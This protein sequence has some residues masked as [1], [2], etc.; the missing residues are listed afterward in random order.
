MYLSSIDLFGFKSFAQKTHISFS[1]GVTAI[2]GPN[3]CGKS[4]LVDA[5]RWV[6]GEQRE[7]ALR[8]ER[9]ENVIFGGTAKRRPLGMAE[10]SLTLH[11]SD[12][13]LPLE[14]HEVTVTRRLFRSG[15]SEYL[16]NKTLCRLK[17][18]VD[19]FMDTGVSPE[20]YS[21]IELKMV[22][23]IVTEDPSEMR[24]L[25]DEATGVT[26][27]KYR[28]R[29]ALRRLDEAKQDH[30]RALDILSEVDK[31]AAN[32]KKQV[33]KLRAYKRL[34]DKARQM[35]LVL[36]LNRIRQ[37]QS[38][39]EP[40]DDAL[41]N[42]RSEMEL[43]T[44]HLQTAEAEVLRIEGEIAELES[45]RQKSILDFQQVEAEFNTRSK[46][47]TRLEE[48]IRLNQWKS[49]RNQDERDANG[50]EQDRIKELI[51][52]AD[53]ALKE[54][55][56]KLPNLQ[57]TLSDQEAFFQQADLK[58][59]EARSNSAQVRENLNQVRGKESDA[60]RMAEQ[61]KASISSLIGR[62]AELNFRR[63]EMERNLNSKN[64]ELTAAEQ[65][66][67]EQNRELVQIRGQFAENKERFEA[68]RERLHEA[69]R[70][71]ADAE[72]LKSQINLQIQHYGELHRRSSPL[73]AAGG[74]I[75]HKFP[76]SVSAAL[77]DELQTETAYIQAVETALQGMA[78]A[79]V[80]NERSDFDP[81][82]NFLRTDKKGRAA[83]LL[84]PPPDLVSSRVQ[85][86]IDKAAGNPLRDIVEGSSDAA[87]WIRYFLAD[88]VLVSSREELV[89]F[90]PL[91]AELMVC[92]VTQDGEFFDDRGIWILGSPD[93]AP[94]APAGVSAQLG[95]LSPQLLVTE[96]QIKALADKTGKLRKELSIIEHTLR[97]TEE[98]LHH[99][100]RSFETANS[101]RLNLEAQVISSR[102]LLE[103]V[104]SE[105][106]DVPGRIEELSSK[107]QTET[108]AISGVI[109]NVREL[110][111]ALDQAIAAEASAMEQREIQ[112]QA[113]A[114]EQIRTERIRLEVSRAQDRVSELQNRYDRNA[115]RL[116]V[117][118]QEL[119]Q[120]SVDRA[121]L[122]HD[123][124]E[125]EHQVVEV[126]ALLQES[127]EKLGNIDFKRR[128]LL[129]AQ[130]NG[131]AQLRLLR[132]KLEEITNAIHKVQL[133]RV[134]IE[135]AL[136]EEQRK[137]P[138]GIDVEKIEELEADA[139][140]LTDLERRILGM[141]PL[142]MAAEEEFQ[143]LQQRLDFLNNQ[144]KD[145]EDAQNSLQQ[146]IT[147]LNKEA[148]ERFSTGFE[149]IRTNFQGIFTE[150]FEG[151]QADMKLVDDDPLESSVEILA[152]PGGKKIGSL[153]LLS[154]G[155]KALTAISLLF[156]IYME[157]PSPF[158]VLD[159]VDA[160]LDDLNTRR[161]CH[162]LEKFTPR[163]QFLV[164]THNKRTMEIAKNLLGITMED[165]GISRVV[166]VQIDL[167]S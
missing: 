15:K 152:N 76:K 55:T 17:D 73:Y 7:A 100:E 6:L 3:G 82:I 130:R 70:E 85:A 147:T 167:T 148:R 109:T 11:D 129:E 42:F 101:Q 135:A 58:F 37:L 2:V 90:A 59:R 96:A 31:Q 99:A 95:K 9:M 105:I 156:A 163:T 41:N 154:G 158:C 98:Q 125:L 5:I 40:L 14:Y 111:T 161:F 67:K 136:Q 127:R 10:I 117:L 131:S 155:E 35:R 120:L 13:I 39:L 78:Y 157:K 33:A 63:E 164:V 160:P 115:D 28:R 144:L 86:F 80:V 45:E 149:R 114:E 18:V 66:Q 79:R 89:K 75:A 92:L 97:T 153:A 104:R 12:G 126:T 132:F 138:Q 140:L 84:G 51:S 159:E 91:A 1:P 93:A 102:L 133:D 134:E 81:I 88:V 165:E 21:I 44:G 46:E 139:E 49:N 145:L 24:Y 64:A 4:N 119:A 150:V 107:E 26:R 128:D 32:L 122:Q 19:L 25:L 23:G 106:S 77:A 43:S 124:E 47:K 48:A 142:N 113:L 110:E 8:S 29:E 62:L 57:K 103:Q 20:S 61:C 118:D 69:E 137:L 72:A 36:T 56:V 50:A 68:L 121:D 30:D 27:Y 16:L 38:R 74:S 143:Q 116:K 65:E 87:A 22:E 146:T 52:P 162:L 34:Q 71:S 141:E 166:P 151:G 94:T 108:Q 123:S 112:R 53:A 54:I 83:L 60:I